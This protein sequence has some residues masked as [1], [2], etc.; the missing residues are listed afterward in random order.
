MIWRT[1]K[2]NILKTKHPSADPDAVYP[3]PPDIAVNVSLPIKSK[4]VWRTSHLLR[5]DQSVVLI[6]LLPQRLKALVAARGDVA[7]RLFVRCRTGESDRNQ[8]RGRRHPSYSCKNTLRRQVGKI[9][10]RRVMAAIGELVRPRQLGYGAPGG[11]KAVVHA[12]R[13][14][15]E[16]EA[17]GI[18]WDIPWE[19]PRG[20]SG[21]L[22]SRLNAWYLNDG[23]LGDTV[24]VVPED[25]QSV[26]ATG[27]EICLKLNLAKCEAFV[28]AEELSLL[29]APLLLEG[30]STLRLLASR[31]G[32]LPVHRT[33]FILRNRLST[34]NVP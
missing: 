19:I 10:N 5:M 24:D 2:K 16:E 21:A 30:L 28:F 34:P 9:A 23:F 18:P 22:R 7:G 3:P 15:L 6:F 11:A 27:R 33:L 17:L 4:D 14:F 20:L 1:K 13:N 29:V 26:M 32:I 8:Q 12:T 25:L 31:L